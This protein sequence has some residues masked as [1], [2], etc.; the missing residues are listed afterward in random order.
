MILFNV[1]SLYKGEV[2]KRPSLYCKT[3]YVADVYLSNSS[4]QNLDDSITDMAHTAALGCCGLADKG[5]TVYMIKVENTKNVCS[6]K[7]LMSEIKEKDTTYL[8]GIDPKIAENVVDKCISLNLLKRLSSVRSYAREKTFMNS[9]FDFTGL[10]E[11]GKR[12]ILEVK[13]V[14]LADYV[15]CAAKEKSKMNFDDKKVHEKIAYFPD[16]YRK[17]AKV[18]ISERALKHITELKDI[19][20]EEGYR[21]ILC[22]VIQRSDVSSFQPSNI[23][24]FYKRAVQDAVANGVELMTIVCEWDYEGNIKFITEDLPINLF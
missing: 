20:L 11:N 21:T 17:T 5:A 18:P 16:G 22:F 6:Y 10:D 19:H 15:D 23:D 4:E 1:G 14:P 24:V 2:I 13:N 3:P 9:R 12:F 7:I 8:V